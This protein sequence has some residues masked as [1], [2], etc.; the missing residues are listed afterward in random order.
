MHRR[1]QTSVTGLPV[2]ATCHSMYLMAQQARA[3]DPIKTAGHAR[4][5]W[6]KLRDQ[7][8]RAVAPISTCRNDCLISI[9]TATDH[10]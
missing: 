9:L 5:G 2:E 1:Q 7:H 6:K 4:N 8:S 10:S 3:A